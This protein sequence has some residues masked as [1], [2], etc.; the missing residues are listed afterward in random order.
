MVQ[1]KKENYRNKVV[2]HTLA[3]ARGSRNLN[4]EVAPGNGNLVKYVVMEKKN[5]VMESLKLDEA[6]DAFNKMEAD[7][8]GKNTKQKKHT[9]APGDAKK[10][11]G[12]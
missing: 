7:G 11:R 10:L 4:M 1:L 12:E 2:R 9:I 3:N 5:V 8:P 6:I